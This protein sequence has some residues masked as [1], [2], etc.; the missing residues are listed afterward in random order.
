MLNGN[1]A[2]E[3]C[4]WKGLI[5]PAYIHR[6]RKFRGVVKDPPDFNPGSWIGASSVLVDY[7]SGEFWLTARPRRAPP[8][9]GYAMIIYRSFDGEDYREAVRLTTEDLT[10]MSSQNVASIEAQQLIRD[11]ATGKY[12][13]Y[14]SVDTRGSGEVEGRWDTFLLISDDPSGPWKYHGLAWK[15]GA[16]YDS[17]EARDATIGIV[18]GMYF[19]L[20]KASNAPKGEGRTNVALATSRDGLEWRKHGILKVNGEAQPDYLQLYGGIFAGTM[21]PVFIGLARRYLINGCGL[22]R[23]FEAYIIDYRN[24]NLELLYRAYWKPLSP[25]EREDY[26][27][28][29]YMNIIEDPYRNRILLYLESIDP[30]YTGEIGWRS[31]VDRLILYET[32]MPEL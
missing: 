15:R 2:F 13:L 12:Y 3:A 31:Q 9:R 7:D 20:Y 32:R 10:S 25:Y 19:A 1:L 8:L 17:H 6:N 23:H 18:D 5:P 11:P 24:M 14:V 4:G 16:E 30:K 22:A 26:P 21:G 28:H 29:G 27:S